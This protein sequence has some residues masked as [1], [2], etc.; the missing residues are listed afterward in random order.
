[1]S[2]NLQDFSASGAVFRYQHVSVLQ[3]RPHFVSQLGGDE[4][5]IV[6]TGFM[7]PQGSDLLCFVG[8]SGPVVARWETAEAVTCDTQS[9]RQSGPVPITLQVCDLQ[10]ATRVHKTTL[11]AAA[12]LIV[13]ERPY[14]QAIT[15]MRG[16]IRGASQI[17]IH[18]AALPT[19]VTS[20]CYF[21]SMQGVPTLRSRS[22]YEC[23]TPAAPKSMLVQVTVNQDTS[24]EP[25]FYRYFEEP[26]V[27]TAQP[28]KGPS[29]GG[30]YIEVGGLHFDRASA[31]LNELSCMFNVTRVPATFVAASLMTCIAPQ[32]KGGYIGIEVSMNLMDYSR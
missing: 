31:E 17:T 19:G 6:G 16:P 8:S 9:T 27:I 22:L 18:G 2:S 11:K 1:M 10:N 3:V 30:T 13:N 28:S 7:P 21:G 32:G 4:L 26:I 29:G 24:A 23:F 5:T 14:I 15:P 25:L 20:R 12:T